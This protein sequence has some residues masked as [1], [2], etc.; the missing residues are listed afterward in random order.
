M[1]ICRIIARF[2][3][4]GLEPCIGNPLSCGMRAWAGHE[5]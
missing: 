5:S 3:V 1:S 2:I 4:H